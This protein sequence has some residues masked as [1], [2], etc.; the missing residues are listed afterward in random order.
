MQTIDIKSLDTHSFEVRIQ[1]L[2]ATT[3]IVSVRPDYAEKLVGG[4]VPLESLIK[5]S[6]EF[7]LERESN[8]SILRSFDL[9]VIARY[10]P[11][12]E[13]EIGRMLAL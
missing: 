13:R 6:F 2:S 3:H 11:E 7:L 8:T 12:Y 10:F 4:T 5:K 9:S 1:G